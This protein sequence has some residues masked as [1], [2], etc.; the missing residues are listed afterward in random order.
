MA[1]VKKKTSKL[2]KPFYETGD[3]I[4]GLLS[5]SSELKDSKLKELVKKLQEAHNK[6][7][8]HLES[9]YIWD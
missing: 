4:G 6:I 3:K 2:R 7:Y 8:K 9:N 5:V 1:V